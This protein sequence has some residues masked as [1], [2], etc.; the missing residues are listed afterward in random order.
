MTLI[1]DTVNAVT[2]LENT[3]DV[4]LDFDIL[5][6]S[7]ATDSGFTY[8]ISG[9]P[10][11][12]LFTIDSAS[13]ELSFVKGP[14]Y[15]NALDEGKDNVYNLSVTANGFG[16]TGT[17]NIAITVTDVDWGTGY[18]AFFE[19]SN[20]D[21]SNGFV[22]NGAVEGDQTG[23]SVSDAGDINGDGYA[24][25]IIGSY[26]DGGKAGETYVVFGFKTEGTDHA[27]LELSSL[28]GR[29]GF[30]LVGVTNDVSGFSV[31]SAGDIN[32]DGND[33]I[34]IGAPRASN[35]NGTSYVVFGQGRNG[36]YG[37]NGVV[38]LSGLDGSDGFKLTGKVPPEDPQIQS[39][40]GTSVSGV[41]DLNGD[42]YDDLIIGAPYAGGK[43]KQFGESYVVFGFDDSDSNNPKS[44]IDLGSL[45]SSN[46]FTLIGARE[47][48]SSGFS[49]SDAGDVNGDGIDDLII[50]APGG[51]YSSNKFGQSYVVFGQ[52]QGG[53]YGND[54]VV[55][56]SGLDGS[57][58]F[59][60]NG[61]IV[62][63][64]SGFSVSGAGDVNGDGYD[65]VIIGAPG[66]T[67]HPLL[68]NTTGESYVVFG[69]NNN[70]HTGGT[71]VDA[72]ELS[73]L[74]GHNGFKLVGGANFDQ[75]GISVSGA[76]DVNGDD[77]DDVIIGSFLADIAGS[78][79]NE[80]AAYVVFGFNNNPDD[81]GTR[82]PVI[83]LA[84]L[85]DGNGFK[86]N[87]IDPGDHTG[88]AVSGARDVNGDGYDDLIISAYRA[89][90]NDINESGEVYIVYGGNKQ[91]GFENSGV[92]NAGGLLP[93]HSTQPTA[94]LINKRISATP[95]DDV[96]ECGRDDDIVFALA[97]ND[98]V[99]GGNGHD[100]IGAGTGNDTIE[101]GLGADLLFGWLGDDLIYAGFQNDLFLDHSSNVVWA[102]PGY[103]TVVGGA[104]A[105]TLGG[106]HDDD[107]VIG[108]RGDDLLFGGFGKD[109][110]LGDQGLDTIYGGWGN[111]MVKGGAHSD[112][113]FGGDG[114]DILQGGSGNDTLWG[115][116]G[117]DTLYGG[118]GDD[119]IDGGG[120][121]DLIFNS[122]GN[123]TVNGGNGDDILWGGPGDDQL[124]GGLGADTFGFTLTN[125]N[126]RVTDFNL[127][128]DILDVSETGFTGLASITS[129][130]EDTDDGLLITLSGSTSVLF[131]GLTLSDLTAMDITYIS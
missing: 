76:G 32:G 70:T 58:G 3:S 101:G 123:D 85:N 90:P 27:V 57:D 41:G 131:T 42:G 82:I 59:K 74:D 86:L 124:T 119:Y 45:D 120:D 72:I 23:W 122:E 15:E 64:K 16:E 29:D 53:S 67:Y 73:S 7:G 51:V 54:N 22:L 52:G 66:N 37:E 5:L 43:N 61:Y 91:L 50:G 12:D 127:D 81:G 96:L 68:E 84:T 36:S 44:V 31:S 63:G 14:D 55:N 106:G 113:L 49:V 10:D 17:Q 38:N 109:T 20:L 60:L 97:G 130:A 69:F 46:G 75:S 77:Y 110:V 79:T 56:L 25:V 8:T 111:D 4:V 108:G 95:F 62:Q 6:N 13:G 21:G 118:I 39:G 80:G 40:S 2:V 65:D 26:R 48:G 19:L 30:K 24:D 34:I 83:E 99:D 94:S 88:K 102:G 121:A 93:D 107:S 112:L 87:G 1:F 47:N 11:Q 9:G 103:D 117:A 89:D 104:G 98:Y 126:D 33:D 116:A 114:R 125:G 35:Y 92:T 28:D 71:V 105:D 129:A 18:A 78:N 128:D 115:D 100:T